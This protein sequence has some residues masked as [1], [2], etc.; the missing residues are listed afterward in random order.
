MAASKLE[1]F[2]ENVDEKVLECTICFKRLKNP[3]SLICLHSF[4]LA[5]L[6][7]WVKTKEE[8]IC[9]TCSKS[10]PVPK[11]GLQK[12]PPNTFLNN[13]LETIEQFSEKDHMKCSVCQKEEPVKYYCQDCRQ[14]LCSTCIDQHKKF[15]AMANH[16]LHLM[17][18]VQSMSPSQMTLLHPPLCSHHSKPLEFYCTD[19]KTPICVHCILMD[20]NAWNGKHKSINISDA[21][22][23]FKETSVTLQK[24]AQ[25]FFNKLED[26]LKAV[27]KNAT[28]LDKCKDTCLR[29][30]DNHVEEIFKKVKENRDKMKNE[31]E[32]IYKR[33]KKVN[34]VQMDEL[35]T[36]ISD[37]NTKLSFLHQ[38][39]KSDEG[40]AMQSSETVITALKDRINELPKTEPDDNGNIYFFINK[41]QMA[42]LR[43][44]DIGTI[45]E[46]RAADCL[47]LKGEESV[48]KDQ[49][50][51]VKII[52]TEEH[53]I[54][55]SQLKAT[56][57][58][59]TGETNIS[60][61]QEDDN[62]D[63]FVTGKCTSP[64]VCKLDVSAGD[65]PINQS[66]MIIKVEEG[67]LVNTIEVNA[68]YITDVVKCEDDFLLVSCAT[69]EMLKYK[70]SGEYI[71]INDDV[72]RQLLTVISE[73]YDQMG[74]INMLKVLYRDL[75]KNNYELNKATK[76]MDLMN[77]LIASGDLHSTH[78]SLLYDTINITKQYGLERKIQDVLPVYQIGKVVEISEFTHHRRKVMKLGM[79][80]V[81]YTHLDVYKRQPLKNTH[82]LIGDTSHMHLTEKPTEEF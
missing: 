70:Q 36:K 76:V 13:L 59:P 61:I 8:L 67:R 53:E 5:C 37:I 79:V 21:F 3:K 46:F 57:I 30:I 41:Q 73:W 17:E 18:D 64:G 56:W 75:L 23:T 52:E 34:D 2:L 15:K 32:T 47:T 26:G 20:H 43:Q 11:G 35:K 51:I 28:K 1:Q 55:A 45:K 22:Q 33:K 44:C 63:Y 72:F 40:T 60:Q 80:P 6:E 62:G 9:P 68:T 16:K 66:P 24:S 14:Y 49:T 77:L 39:L 81:S 78:L 48:I 25:H 82:F 71:E 31:V 65:K 19:C 74:Y 7:D 69:N 50:F 12:L 54:Y 38:L 29:D 10:Y 58:Q 42:S 27:I 4:C